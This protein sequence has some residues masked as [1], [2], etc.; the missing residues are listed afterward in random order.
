MMNLSRRDQALLVFLIVVLCGFVFFWFV[1][2]PVNKE[3]QT[4]TAH[5]EQ[6]QIDKERLQVQIKKGPAKTEDAEDKFAHLDKRLP[7]EDEMIPLLT[8]LDETIGK[9][10]L[11]FA[12]LDYK[13]AEKP[14]ET[15]AQTLVFT[16]GTKGR[17]ML[18]L[19]FLN[20][21]ENA[22]RLISVEDV[23]FNAVKAENVEKQE[24]A[25]D[26]GPPTYYIAPPGIPEAKL[27]RIKFEVVEEKETT[28]ATTTDSE[29][30][31]AESFMPD[32]FEMKVTI[33]AYYATPDKVAENG[34]ADA[35]KNDAKKTKG[36]V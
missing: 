33:N 36:E 27:Q 18:L 19:D 30:P 15:G 24:T 1:Y 4:L 26:P 32:N 6:L 11:P 14:S 20:D 9:Y 31:V 5:N 8:M 34:N 28:S 25:V 12:S 7:T 3:I 16:I 13:G 10:N 29:R 17:L 23:S 21:L 2:L 35:K 22:E